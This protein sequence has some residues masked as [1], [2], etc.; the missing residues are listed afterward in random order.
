MSYKIFQVD[1]DIG[2]EELELVKDCFNRRWLSEGP[3][4]EEFLERFRDISG[5]KFAAFAPNGTL[6][7]Y[8]ALLAMDLPKDSEVIVPAF[9]FYASA[10]A[11]V[12]ANLKPVFVDVFKDSLNIDYNQ[13]E[14]V[15]NKNVSAIMPIHMYGQSC[16]MDKI[17]E[18]AN[19]HKIKVIEDAAQ[20]VSVKYKNK[21][22]GHFGDVGVFSFFSDKIVT[23]GE[24]AVL[25]TNNE[26]LF[27]TIKL[28]RNQGRPNAGTFIHPDLGMNFRVTE[29][30]A[31]IGLA[32]LKKLDKI[33]QHRLEIYDYYQQKLNGLI[34]LEFVK[35]ESF[36]S[37]APFRFSFRTKHRKEIAQYL[38]L[39]GVQTRSCFYPLNKQPKFK[40]YRT[41]ECA[42]SQDAYDLGIC[43][44]VHRSITKKEVDYIC[45]IIKKYCH[46]NNL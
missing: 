31:S 28:R 29:V 46:E 17:M 16:D 19:K 6:G 14:S 10:S 1:L 34:D 40:N 7:L 20:A 45:E 9:T 36:S 13:L 38:E 23:M 25:T 30:Q 33:L 39:N 27:N 35:Q 2:K 41:L 26:E 5:S 22:V 32:Q 21:H 44:P 8:L 15:M 42:V 43:L 12:F 37:L 24:G 18:F 3:K 4:C 11:C